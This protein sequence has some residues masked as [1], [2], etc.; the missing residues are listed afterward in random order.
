MKSP[1][2]GLV[3]LSLA[4]AAALPAQGI[5]RFRVWHEGREITVVDRNGVAIHQGDVIIGRTAE[6]LERSRRAAPN[7]ERIG[8]G[9]LSKSNVIGSADG[10]WPR[11]TSG[12]FE[13]PYVIETDSSSSVPAAINLFNQQLAGLMRAVPR[14]NEPDYVAFTLAAD[15]DSG[16]CASYIGRTGGR[17]EIMGSHLCATGTLVHELGHAIGL[18]H[19]Q[20]HV[21]RD[22]FVVI[23]E[24]KVDPEQVHNYQP[25]SNRR[26]ASP[27]D[28][29]SLMHY[30]SGSFSRDGQVTMETIPPGVFINQRNGYSAGDLEGIRRFYGAPSEQ[31]T[32]TTNPPGLAI[33]VDGVQVQAPAVFSW[34]IGSTH[35]L[36]VPANAQVS[37]GSA[38]VFGRWNVDTAGDLAAR[39]TIT[40][41][42]GNDSITAPTAR[43]A[44]ST[45]TASFVRYKEVRFTTSG[46]GSVS[47]SPAPIGLQGMAGSFYR[48]RQAFALEAVP[49]GSARLGSWAGSYFFSVANTT[50]HSPTFRGPVAFSDSQ[51]AAYEYR[52]NFVTFPFVTLRA[53]A[54]D[55]DVLGISVTTTRGNTPTARLPYNSVSWTAGETATV[56]ASATQTPFS[57]TMRYVFKDWDGNPSPT[58]TVTMPTVF[59]PSRTV[60]ANFSKEYKAY[61][62][63]IPACAGQVT[64]PGT[65]ASW[66]A[67]GSN[68]SVSLNVNPGWVMTGWEGSLSGTATLTAFPVTTHPNVVARLN[69]TNAPLAVNSVSPSTAQAGQATSIEIDGTGFTAASEVYVDGLRQPSTFVNGN[70]L[71]ASVTAAALSTNGLAIVTVVNRVGGC[72]VSEA[73]GIDVLGVAAAD[74]TPQT[75]WWWNA[76]ESGR[77]FFIEKRGNNLFMAGYYYE[78]DG[79]ATWFS[80]AGPMSGSSFTG[81]MTV[82]QGGQSLSGSYRAPTAGTSPGSVTLSFASP[83]S[84]TMTWPGGTTALTR[85]NV[86]GSGGPGV[87]ENGWWWSSSESGRGFSIEVQGNAIFMAG[88]MY[89][90]AGNPMWY[91]AQGSVA[92][93][94]TFNGA[95]QQFA[96]GQALGGIYRA[97]TII[98]GNVGGLGLAF[99]GPKSATLTL[100]NGRV[101]NLTRF[102]F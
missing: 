38:H 67:H 46:T 70:R 54:Q 42:A 26:S 51:Q 92:G 9:S 81:A 76:N 32:V 66:H 33:I 83:T 36:D 39:R 58:T 94:T 1:I 89:D 24:S 72:A 4:L 2:T 28:F 22:R 62:E 53:R 21:D 7:G 37:S 97:P 101:V 31:V 12:L 60:T 49:A 20:E 25:K 52:G 34:A 96:N 86:G 63:V 90:D 5:D 79:R 74:T 15:D 40:V 23:D 61:R 102:E 8:A 6:V 84:A 56:T 13:V 75:G 71:A 77:G 82:Y 44:I 10:R 59:E 55:G 16:A 64:L 69:T 85:F 78:A 11:G 98:N 45:Y 50:S 14:T 29:G 65:A 80:A 93:G 47:P 41:A 57:E 100:P 48:D 17:Q 87:G 35:T 3:S 91:A 73:G 30:G 99:T 18:F 88:F 95:W 43:P 27:Y 68:M 19:E